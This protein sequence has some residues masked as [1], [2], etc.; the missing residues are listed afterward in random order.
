MACR[1]RHGPVRGQ[2]DGMMVLACITKESIPKAIS[3]RMDHEDFSI[4]LEYFLTLHFMQTVSYPGNTV[5]QGGRGKF[6]EDQLNAKTKK[7]A[8][9]CVYLAYRLDKGGGRKEDQ[10]VAPGALLDIL[11]RDEDRDSVE[12]LMDD[13]VEDDKDVTNNDVSNGKEGQN[14]LERVETLQQVH[15]FNW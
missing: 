3:C 9:F 15:N 2:Y 11:I 4:M 14:L 10:G 7:A 6:I 5:V 8:A 13:D 12:E 1:C